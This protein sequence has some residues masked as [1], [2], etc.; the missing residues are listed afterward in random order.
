MVPTRRPRPLRLLCAHY[1]LQTLL[2]WQTLIITNDSKATVSVLY[3]YGNY[4][5]HH[6]Q[7]NKAEWPVIAD[8]YS[9]MLYQLS[10]YYAEGCGRSVLQTLLR[11]QNGRSTTVWIFLSPFVPGDYQG[12]R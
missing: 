8:I 2:G 7:H 3:W 5:T 6:N 1:F 10:Y 12:A 11:M 4:P 9:H